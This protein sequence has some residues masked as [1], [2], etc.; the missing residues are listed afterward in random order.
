[1]KTT[2]LAATIANLSVLQKVAVAPPSLSLG[3][4][5]LGFVIAIVVA[6]ISAVMPARRVQRLEVAVALR[7]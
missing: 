3:V 6:L 1:M 4:I 5:M 2:Y 7:R